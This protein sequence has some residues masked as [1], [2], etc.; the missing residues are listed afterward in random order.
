MDL[1]ESENNIHMTSENT[2][3][4]TILFSEIK[5][6]EHNRFYKE[7]MSIDTVINESA[8]PTTWGISENVQSSVD[9]ENLLQNGI[10]VETNKG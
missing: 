1:R 2:L 9:A 4:N 8:S 5:T 10:L 3:Q 6:V 7:S